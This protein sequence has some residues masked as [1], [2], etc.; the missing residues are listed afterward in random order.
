MLNNCVVPVCMGTGAT[1]GNIIDD[2]QIPDAGLR[3]SN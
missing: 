3:Y 1:S 2:R